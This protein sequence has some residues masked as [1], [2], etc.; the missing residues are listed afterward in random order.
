M[1]VKGVRLAADSSLTVIGLGL[2]VAAAWTLGLVYGLAAAGVA[3][4]VLQWSLRPAPP[5][6][7]TLSGEQLL[8]ALAAAR[9]GRTDDE[10]ID[11]LEA[12]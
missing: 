4:L 6:G 10:I 8:A 3:V 12:T 1:A 5:V 2:L 11:A 7:I 9:A